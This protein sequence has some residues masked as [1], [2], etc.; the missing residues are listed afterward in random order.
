LLDHW[1][2][3]R[4]APGIGPLLGRRLVERFGDP[5][6]VFRAR[7]EDWRA[8]ERIGPVAAEV[9]AKGPDLDAARKEIEAAN[10]V[11]PR[12]VPV[13]DPAYPANLRRIHD[14]PLVLAVRGTLE[15]GDA[16]AAAVVG[17]RGASAYGLRMATYLAGEL[18]RAGIAVVSGLAQ[19]IDAAAH[20]GALAARGRTIAVLGCG[21]DRVYPEANGKLRDEVA[22]S[23]AVISEFP[24]GTPPAPEN[25]PRRNRIISGLSLGVVV[26]EAD[27]K[28]GSLITARCALEQGREVFAVPGNADSPRSRGCHWLIKQG[29]KL[30]DSPADILEEIAPQLRGT[31]GDAARPVAPRLG[32]EER[33]VL[34][35]CE[36]AE[37]VHADEIAEASGLPVSR[38]AGILLTLELQDLLEPLPGQFFR[39]KAN[40]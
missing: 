20:R 31:A 29:A 6:A 13:T 3:L 1:I 28:S 26:V 11:G 14:A 18:A 35:L 30:A 38:L 8:V 24:I 37:R 23:G 2:A 34:A 32:D 33:R 9:L 36:A 12:L 16:K 27:R 5:E 22:A 39:R 4:N 21:I 15:P 7:P 10:A 19:G 40:R 25:F 17:S